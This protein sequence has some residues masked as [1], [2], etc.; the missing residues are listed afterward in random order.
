MAI[1]SIARVLKMKGKYV[2]KRRGMYV[3]ETYKTESAAQG[4]ADQ[5]NEHTAL[6]KKNKKKKS[7]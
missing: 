7:K 2:V 4:I 1:D 6:A 5:W 3:S